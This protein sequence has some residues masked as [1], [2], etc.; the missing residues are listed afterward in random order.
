MKIAKRRKL[1]F[2]IYF[3]V[4]LALLLSMIVLGDSSVY[5]DFTA[6]KPTYAL[7]SRDGD[8]ALFAGLAKVL[9][10]TGTPV[11]IEDSKEAMMDAGFYEA[12]DCIFVV[13][14]GYG[15][16]FWNGSDQSL[17]MWQWPSSSSG[18]YLRS[19]AEQYLSLV[20]MY[21]TTGEMSREEMAEAAAS[22]MEKETEVTIRR[23]TDGAVASENV[24]LFQRFLP[25]ILLL[26]CISGVS[27]VFMPFKKTEIRMRNLCSPVKPGTFAVGKLLY[28]CVIGV[29]GWFLLNMAGTITFIKDVQQL[30]VKMY[31]LYLF[32]SLAVM[33]VA[34]SVALLC[35]AFV[36]GENV[37]S[38]VTNI[39]ALS[40][41]FLSG[42][43]VPLEML[44]GGIL[45]VAKFIPV[46]W[47]EQN[48]GRISSLTGFAW[49]DVKSVYEGILI[50]VG[51]AAAFFCIYLLV[52]KYQEQAEESF[53]SVKTEIE[54]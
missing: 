37:M 47:F 38:F 28:S 48:E 9:E 7:I 53:G 35:S 32:N 5:G 13:P 18:Y 54:Q 4:Y 50:Q 43:F 3:C 26:L 2:G 16:E 15:E 10:K 21:Q 46:Y 8:S 19:A 14:K 27:I 41:S 34:I 1:T 12:V 24:R 6:Q 31:V 45:K 11:E 39:V 49:S 29:G 52:S 40:M 42:V 33:L 22:S 44:G 23:Y 25:Y 51:F 17:E 30:D 20:R 36:S